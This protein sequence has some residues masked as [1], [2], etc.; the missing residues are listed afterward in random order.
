MKITEIK[1]YK[2]EENMT[3]HTKK[4]GVYYLDNNI[5]SLKYENDKKKKVLDFVLF[6]YAK[7]FNDDGT[8]RIEIVNK[9]GKT[10]HRFTV[11]YE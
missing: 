2:K 10:I 6:N 8:D 5:A 9:K 11:K 3:Q 4:F 7:R 1:K